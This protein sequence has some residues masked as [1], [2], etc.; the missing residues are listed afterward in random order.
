MFNRSMIAL[1]GAAAA[2][3]LPTAASATGYIQYTMSGTVSGTKVSQPLNGPGSIQNVSGRAT[4]TYIL[5]SGG[6]T[7]PTSAWF[8]GGQSN[9]GANSF[10]E[11]GFAGV[12]RGEVSGTACQ[13]AGGIDPSCGFAKIVDGWST[14]SYN[15]TGTIDSFT[16][17]VLTSPVSSIGFTGYALNLSPVVTASVSVNQFTSTVAAVPEPATWISMV[18]GFALLGVALRRRTGRKLAAA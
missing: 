17:T 10:K 15:L 4:F 8:L 6:S 11:T 5:P 2:A 14:G 9:F 18:A 12:G 13:G 3:M 1:A 7:G 16:S